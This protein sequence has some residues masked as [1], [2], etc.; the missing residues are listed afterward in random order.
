MAYRTD[1]Q[2]FR[3]GGYSHVSAHWTTRFSSQ[4]YVF[5]LI[6]FTL[7]HLFLSKIVPPTEDELYYWSWAQSLH[8]SFFDHPPLVAILIKV[9]TALFGNTLFGIRFFA[10]I[11]NLLIFLAIASITP[12]KKV[13]GLVLLTPLVFF[14]SILMTPDIPFLLFWTL[15]LLWL[16]SINKSFSQWGGDPISRVYRASPVHWERWVLG[17]VLLGLGILSKYSMVLAIPCAVLVLWTQYRLASWFRGMVL[18]C[19]VAFFVVSPIVLFNWKYHFAPFMFQ[20]NHS[21]SEGGGV[22]GEFLS[23]QILLVG[24]LPLLMLGWVLLRKNDICSQPVFHVCFYCFVFPFIFSIFQAAKT[25]VEANWALMSYIAFWPLAQHLINQNSIR[26][27]EYLMLG[28]GFVPPL[29]AT[30]LILV[31]MIY[32]LKFLA[33]EKDRL[34][35]HQALY[36]VMKTMKNDLEQNMRAEEHFFLPTY[37][38]TAY[39]KY[40][41]LKADQ[42]FPL[43]RPSQYTLEPV[44]PCQFENIIVLSD[45]K[46]P[47]YEALRCFPEHTLLKEYSIE[48]RKK[49]VSQL[50]LIEFFRN[51]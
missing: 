29:L 30:A 19:V 2:L 5:S 43:G 39:F 28:L 25:H 34:G 48:V 22:F 26:F 46:E 7:F 33:P 1:N 31:H 16:V 49:T 12:G 20:W 51:S 8:W 32:P 41:G 36:E 6:L 18:L 4:W 11:F 50:Y 44:D 21:L 38:L 14:G 37:Q 24:A 42:I 15:F 17:G 35:K 9:S 40:L 45:S 3:G 13:L 23:G 47:N 27:L 10:S